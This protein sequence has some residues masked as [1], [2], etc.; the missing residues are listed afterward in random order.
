MPFENVH[1]TAARV[2]ITAPTNIGSLLQLY[3]RLK[4]SLMKLTK[5]MYLN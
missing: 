4:K 3:F 1:S 5:F 2:S